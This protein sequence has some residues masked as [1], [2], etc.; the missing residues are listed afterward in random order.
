MSSSAECDDGSFLTD[1]DFGKVDGQF[2]HA[3]CWLYSP[4]IDVQ[5]QPHFGQVKV[6]AEIDWDAVRSFCLLCLCFVASCLSASNLRLAFLIDECHLSRCE[7]SC[8]HD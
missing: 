2:L 1:E 8:C 7:A 4:V 3:H 6:W 5:T